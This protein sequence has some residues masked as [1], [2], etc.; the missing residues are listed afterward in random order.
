MT[1]G[2]AAALTAGFV[3]AVALGV[4]IGPS[5]TDRM[6]DSARMGSDASSPKT[7]EARPAPERPARAKSGPT[8][9]AKAKADEVGAEPVAVVPNAMRADEPRV[10]ERLKPVLNRGAKMEIAAEGFLTAEEFAT[11]AHAA[12]NTTV[13]FMVLKHRVLNE[14]R[15][16]E[17]SMTAAIREF[18]P[19]LDA[20]AE[21]ARAKREAR[22]D[23]AD[24]SN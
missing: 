8:T 9:V 17:E 19:D 15:P 10:Q 2:K 24:I 18:K 20:K 1:F 3:G 5:V 6:S 11:V 14:K 4:A 16:L 22:A 23:I 12:R 21:V 7:E 13:P